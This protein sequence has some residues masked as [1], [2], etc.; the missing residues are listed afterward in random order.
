MVRCKNIRVQ[1]C[2]SKFCAEWFPTASYQKTDSIAA[3]Q[4]PGESVN[5]RREFAFSFEW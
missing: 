1:Q 4:E 3:K 5:G 2:R